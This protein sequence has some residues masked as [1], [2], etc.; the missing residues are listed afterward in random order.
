MYL[1]WVTYQTMTLD[2]VTYPQ[3]NVLE[4]DAEIMLND[5]TLDRLKAYDEAD[6]PDEV[7]RLMANLVN[8]LYSMYQ[9]SKQL[10][11]GESVKS[12]SNGVSSWSFDTPFSGSVQ[13]Y[14]AKAKAAMYDLTVQYLPVELISRV[15][16]QGGC[17]PCM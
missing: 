15:V 6:M 10:L 17:Y 16:P 11:N 7:K 13:D 4:P 1:D 12:Y 3:F 5:W 8:G 2:P 14:E 9:G